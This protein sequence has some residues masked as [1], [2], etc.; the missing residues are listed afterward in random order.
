[1]LLCRGRLR[2][3]AGTSG[4]HG[5]KNSKYKFTKRSLENGYRRRIVAYLKPQKLTALSD[6]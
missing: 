1:M 5:N 6:L 2:N 3:V 4:I